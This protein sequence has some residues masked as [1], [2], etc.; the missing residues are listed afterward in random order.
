MD[1]SLKKEGRRW[2]N[3]DRTTEDLARQR[4]V[5]AARTCYLRAGINV[6]TM[7]QIADEASVVRATLYR[8]FKTK[9]DVLRAVFYEEVK[10]FLE[11]FKAEQQ[12]YKGFCDYLLQF[13]LYSRQNAAETPIHQQFFSEDS[14]IWVSREYLSDDSALGLTRDLFAEPFRIAQGTGEIRSDLSLDL[15]VEWLARILLSFIFVPEPQA[16]S[17]DELVVLFETLLLRAIRV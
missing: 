7:S 9:Q 15:L 11:Q 14:A 2:G 8:Y 16:R 5:A 13:L 1:T 10:I 4:I 6:T 17:E 12:V 3:G